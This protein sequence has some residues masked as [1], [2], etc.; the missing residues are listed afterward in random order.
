M[1]RAFVRES[2]SET[3]GLPD[4]PVSPHPN[5]VTE[6]GRVAI[7]NALHR[8]EAA[9]KAALAKGD[10]RAA[11][12]DLREVKYWKA[13]LASAQ[14][15]KASGDMSHA[16]FGAN[17][18]VRRGDGREQTFRIVGED[19]ANPSRGTVSHMSPIARAVIGRAVGETVEIA[20]QEAEI[21][22][23]SSG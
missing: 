5:F 11:A 20:G 21:L 16:H 18:T 10:E 8:F 23:I 4:R 22:K 17:V 12:A 3:V 9:H 19:E 13:R 6:P 1:S 14:V 7:E 15:I 2:E